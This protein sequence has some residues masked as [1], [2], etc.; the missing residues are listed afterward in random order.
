MP[1][2]DVWRDSTYGRRDD[3]LGRQVDAQR[4]AEVGHLV[5]VGDAAAVDPVEDLTAVKPAAPVSSSARSISARSSSEIHGDGPF[6]TDS[7]SSGQV[8][9]VRTGRICGK[10]ARPH[11]IILILTDSHKVKPVNNLE[12]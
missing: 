4:L 7:A 9:P 6:S 8:S 2:V 12:H 3:E 1:S 10:Q 5:E 11:A